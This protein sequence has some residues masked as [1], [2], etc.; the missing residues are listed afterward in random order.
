[1][2]AQV[3]VAILTR[4]RG[5]YV[6]NALRLVLPQI[7][8]NERAGVVVIDIDCTDDTATQVAQLQ[9]Q[10]PLLCYERCAELGPGQSCNHEL[11]TTLA[12]WL[13]ILDDDAEPIA[14]G[15]SQVLRLIDDDQF[16]ALGGLY[17]ACFAE[18]LQP[19]FHGRCESNDSLVPAGEQFRMT[20]GCLSSGI[21]AY[22]VEMLRQAG[23]LPVRFGMR[24][25]QVGY[26]EEP[27][28]RQQIAMRGARLGVGRRCSVHQL[29]PQRKQR[30]QWTRR[31][32][33]AIGRDFWLILDKPAHWPLQRHCLRLELA[34]SWRQTGTA[35]SGVGSGQG[36]QNL[37]A[38]N[39]RWS[40]LAGL[41]C[42]SRNS[43]QEHR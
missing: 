37:L 28:A 25:G 12:P 30:R 38:E 8:G 43:Q 31:C 6:A 35:L 22:R 7:V 23:G 40:R 32:Q 21:A 41:W 2:T 15:V 33:F 18:R 24:C 16:N 9:Q 27:P 29:V 5:R 14:D 26:G 34:N 1:M 36:W 17:A 11:A 19:W 4:S 13:A 3:D 42:G 10:W 20:K 39:A